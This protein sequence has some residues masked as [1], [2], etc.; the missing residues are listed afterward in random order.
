[1]SIIY[2]SGKTKE[3][4]WIVYKSVWRQIVST[5]RH[6]SVCKFRVDGGRDMVDVSFYVRVRVVAKKSVSSFGCVVD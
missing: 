4:D 1:M 5:V 6:G 3:G 2:H